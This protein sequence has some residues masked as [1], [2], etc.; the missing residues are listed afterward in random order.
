MKLRIVDFGRSG[1][2]FGKDEK[3][4]II[5]IKGNNKLKKGDVVECELTQD[6][7]KCSIAKFSK[8]LPP[9]GPMKQPQHAAQQK[10]A[11]QRPAPQPGH[12]QE[13]V[14]RKSSGNEEQPDPRTIGDMYSIATILDATTRSL[15]ISNPLARESVKRFIDNIEKGKIK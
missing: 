11:Q 10:S 3:G 6:T 7:A 8:M 2:P 5:F 1:D 15:L 4:K 14:L 12:E 13:A 9:E